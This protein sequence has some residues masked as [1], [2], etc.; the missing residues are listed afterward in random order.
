MLFFLFGKDTFRS[1]EKLREIKE[2][3]LSQDNSGSGLSVLDY[4]EKL[5]ANA[6]GEALGA[7]SLFSPKRLVVS[8]NCI[9]SSTPEIQKEVLALLKKNEG[10][11]QDKDVTVIFWEKDEPRKNNALFKFL[12]D[13]AK[14]Q[15]FH[16]LE[17]KD[18]EK[19]ITTKLQLIAPHSKLE[20]LALTT[21]L[22]FSGND[23]SGLET[24]LKKL[25]TYRPAGDITKDDVALLVKSK[26]SNTIFETIEAISAG[27]KSKALAL[28]HQQVAQGE[29]PFYILSMYVYQIRNLLKIGDAFWHGNTNQYAIAKEVG[30]H[31]FVVQKGMAQLRNLNLEKLISL[32]SQLQQIDQDAKTGKTNLLLALD[33][34]ISSL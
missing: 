8:I 23:I 11:S 6:L 25:A 2:K 3:F 21:L 26:A 17:G 10:L 28:L 33:T 22:A 14:K 19:W 29:D 12:S 18:L 4:E 5:S 13:K 9:Q 1:G 24:E 31:P 16:P 20:P 7:S 27:Q 30:L 32:H 34:F 15:V